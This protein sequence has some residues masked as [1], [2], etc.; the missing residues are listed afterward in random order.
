MLTWTVSQGFGRQPCSHLLRSTCGFSSGVGGGSL[1]WLGRLGLGRDGSLTD[2][3]Q[4]APVDWQGQRVRRAGRTLSGGVG[5]HE[6][7]PP[8]MHRPPTAQRGQRFEV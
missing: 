5:R 7:G 4:R 3:A 1:G 6:P 2:G 8:I